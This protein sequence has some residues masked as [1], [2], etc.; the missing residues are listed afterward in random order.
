MPQN[1]TTVKEPDIL[2]ET[3]HQK[4]KK[5]KDLKD[6]TTKDLMAPNAT[7]AKKPDTWPKIVTKN[8]PKRNATTAKR[9]DTSP[10]IALKELRKSQVLNATNVTKLVILPEIAKVIFEIYSRLIDSIKSKTMKGV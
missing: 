9:S 5:E 2:P 7:T 8:K 1:A 6:H 3:A 4:D 10:E